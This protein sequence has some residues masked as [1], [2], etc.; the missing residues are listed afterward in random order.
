LATE[1]AAERGGSLMVTTSPRTSVEAAD[2][3]EAA[4]G[5]NILLHRWSPGSDNP[6]AA[7]LASA[8]AFI[9]TGDSASMVA[10]ACARNKPLTIFPLSERLELLPAIGPLIHRLA[11]WRGGRVSYRGTPKQQDVIDR[12]YD[13]LVDAGIITPMRDLDA[14]HHAIKTRGL[15]DG[16]TPPQPS[17]M[18]RAVARLQRL[19]AGERRIA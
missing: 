1:T 11:D 9:V 17:D 4:L 7:F 19:I 6:Y 10:E 18:D 5:A 14:Y 3:L 15:A 12:I 16:T 2:A 8:D 13:R